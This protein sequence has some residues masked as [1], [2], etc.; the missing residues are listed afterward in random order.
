MV[1]TI[2]LTL[3]ACSSDDAGDEARTTEPPPTTSAPPTTTDPAPTASAGCET[4]PVA[5]PGTTDRTLT[6]GQD[7]HRYQVTLPS[8]YD[9]REPLPLVLGLHALS[10]PHTVVPAIYG[11]AD[12]A[13]QRDFILVAPS[14][15]VAGTAPYWVAAPVEPNHDVTFIADLLD[16]LDADLCFDPA[17]VF[18][19]GM[20][21]GGQMSSLLACRLGDR[22]TAVAPVAGVEFSDDTCTGGPVPV[23]AFHGDADPIVTYEG[24]GLNATTIADQQEWHGD[25]PDGLPVHGGVDQALADW[26]AHNGC[27]PEPVEERISP[28]VVRRSWEGC[29]A[30]TVLYVVEGGGHTWPGRPAPGFEDQFGATTVDIDATALLVDFF[31][32]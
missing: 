15:L 8:A 28:E 11:L 24:G 6:S 26:A 17:Q 29:A 7:E 2:A 4:T 22:I 12:A 14:G 20:S 21:N 18:S 9:G 30:E 19:T 3:T 25:V 13:E 1:L 23:M 31:L 16:R 10:V 27:A 32:D 5:R